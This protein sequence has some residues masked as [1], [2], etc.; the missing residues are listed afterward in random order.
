[1]VG[2]LIVRIYRAEDLA[3][4]DINGKSDPFVKMNLINQHHRTSTQYK[5][6]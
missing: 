6:K 1:M 3:A 4:A 2:K 5:S